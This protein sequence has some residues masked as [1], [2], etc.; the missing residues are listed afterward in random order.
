MF[1]RKNYFTWGRTL[2]VCT[3]L[4]LALVTACSDDDS[5][6]EP[7]PDVDD[8]DTDLPSI[9]ITGLQ[10]NAT[11]WNTVTLTVTADDNEAVKEVELLIDNKSV[12]TKTEKSFTYALNTAEPKLAD[13]PHTLTAVVTDD[14]DNEKK[15]EYTFTIAN[16]LISINVPSN[17]L[18]EGERGF[19]F[20]SDATGKVIVSQQYTNNQEIR[21]SAPAYDGA[22]FYL[23]EVLID[24][25]DNRQ[26]LGTY[27]KVSRGTWTM[28]PYNPDEISPV[29]VGQ[30]DVNFTHG[31]PDTNYTIVAGYDYT[32]YDESGGEQTR[33]LMLHKNPSR[34]YITRGEDDELP[35][36]YLIT[37]VSVGANDAIDL[38]QVNTK[39]TEFTADL[40][41]YNVNTSWINVYGLETPGDFATS[42]KVF[43]KPFEGDVAKYRYP[44]NAFAHYMSR[45]SLS[46]DQFIAYNQTDGLPDLKPLTADVDVKFEDAKLTG[47]V[48]GDDVDVVILTIEDDANTTWGF[49]TGKGDVNIVLPALPDELKTII[50]MDESNPQIDFTGLQFEFNGYDGLLNYIRNSPTGTSELMDDN[51]NYKQLDIPLTG[52]N[53]E[54]RRRF[55]RK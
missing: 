49:F 1:L 23:T 38:S 52:G 21:L 14:S 45:V 35:T 31:L 32:Y 10:A 40:S 39:L 11:I 53:T 46:G 19:I 41:A 15:L 28:A 33:S 18:R 12:V 29:Y 51:A 34:L 55:V 9:T 47:T 5:A 25:N 16:T 26:E 37:P 30:A 20:L 50:A 6:T 44:G 22:D 24:D 3:S 7:D 27:Q 17:Q 42:Y 2:L 13:G 36:H 43:S 54:G 4:S 48:S 8:P